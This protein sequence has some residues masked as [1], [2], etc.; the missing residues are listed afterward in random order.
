MST[1]KLKVQDGQFI[2]EP[3]FSEDEWLSIL[4]MADNGQHR[5]QIDV[6][7][8]FLCQ[9]GHKATCS[10]VGKEYSL[11]AT[12]V[13]SLVV[14]FCKF[15]QK[16]AGKDFIVESY[17]N[18]NETFWPICMYGRQLDSN[19]F[20]WQI[21]PELANA[22]Q[23]FLLEKLIQEYRG[24]VIKEGLNNSR[25]KELYKWRILA[26]AEGKDIDGI[27]KIMCN[28]SNEMNILTWRTKE[29]IRTA[30]SEHHDDIIKCFSLLT[31]SGR[32]F[33]DS[34]SKFIEDGNSFL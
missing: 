10:K 19:A 7:R 18:S 34:F 28:P 14:H 8:M 22:L 25:S 32:R 1:Y 9:P 16:T 29:A 11:N 2:T 5:R 24:I 33:Y 6:L 23:Y 20:E 15:A 26:S 17:A 21:R 13:N 12:A 4:H 3:I 27:L 31:E 30:L